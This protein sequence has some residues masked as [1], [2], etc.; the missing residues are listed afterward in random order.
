MSVLL[1]TENIDVHGQAMKWALGEMGVHA[2]I[3]TFATFPENQRLSVRI[4]EREEGVE[5][6]NS[7]WQGPGRYTSI[8]LRRPTKPKA[9][10]VALAKTDVEMALHESTL[11]LD[12]LRPVLA[13]R[14]TWINPLESRAQAIS[15]L[16]Q[17]LVAKESGFA[18]PDTLVSNNPDDIRAF[19]REHHGNIIYKPFHQAG[20]ASQSEQ[21]SYAAF[22]ARVTADQLEDDV[23]MTSC[24][25]IYQ[26]YISKRAE[27]RVAFFGDEYYAIRIHSQET[28]DG[29]TDW[30][31]N[32]QRDA[33]LEVAILK[34]SLLEKCKAFVGKMNLLHGSFDIVEQGPGQEA[35]LEV[36]E[37]GQFLWLETK[38]TPLPMLA[39]ASA[40]ACEPDPRFRFNP[41]RWPNITFD[42][43]LQSQSYL[44]FKK[45]WDAYV[46]ERDYPFVYQE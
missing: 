18:I 26:S 27:L 15:K 14:S 23:S 1:I 6:R 16:Q 31:A 37:M 3:W 25:G 11:L 28:T 41:D 10:S 24:P 32:V 30:R 46:E 12:A 19:F 36:N 38:D 42:R 21:A 44:G 2:D 40:F 20:W 5:L 45:L 33:R 7:V 39:A 35:F 29:K 13:A 9:I 17:L 8:W 22:T 43:Y 4:R 34:T